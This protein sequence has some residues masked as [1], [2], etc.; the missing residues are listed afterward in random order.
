MSNQAEDNPT[1]VTP[2]EVADEAIAAEAAGGNEEAPLSRAQR[3]AAQFN[4]TSG[5]NT[6]RAAH[7]TGKAAGGASS[8]AASR[9]SR[10]S[11]KRAARGK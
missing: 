1:E 10:M 11:N 7:D 8:A 5:T 6:L 4:K 3:R 9:V 2:G